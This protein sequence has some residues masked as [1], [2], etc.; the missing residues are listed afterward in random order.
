[1]CR[2]RR[3]SATRRPV[4]AGGDS[5][6]QD[7][8]RILPAAHLGRVASLFIVEGAQ[9]WGTYDAADYLVHV[10]EEALPGDRDLVELAALLTGM[11]GGRVRRVPPDRA[12]NGCL[13][14]AVL[15]APAGYDHE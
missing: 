6:A 5:V 2:P 7:I 9:C 1:M 8:R 13:V 10:H 11:R 4:P 12:R 15:H 14:A 3:R